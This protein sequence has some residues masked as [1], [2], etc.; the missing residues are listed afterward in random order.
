MINGSKR[1]V[2]F[3]DV[4]TFYGDGLADGTASDGSRDKVRGPLLGLRCRG[5]LHKAEEGGE[6]AE[7][8]LMGKK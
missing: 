2:Y 4:L 6:D 8:Q 5:S 1:R 3:F 7:E